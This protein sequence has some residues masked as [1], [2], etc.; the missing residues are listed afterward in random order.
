MNKLPNI[1]TILTCLLILFGSASIN[2]ADPYY[3]W[4]DTGDGGQWVRVYP[5]SRQQKSINPNWADEHLRDP[6]TGFN[7]LDF[8]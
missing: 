2:A 6:D 5:E 8:E 1:L 4:I 3:V 7:D